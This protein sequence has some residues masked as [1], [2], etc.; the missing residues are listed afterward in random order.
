[1]WPPG[2]HVEHVESTGSTNVDLLVAAESGAPDRS[3][4]FTDHQ[5]AGRGRLDRVWTAPPGTNLL[6]S[7]LFRNVP[8]D[9]GELTRRVG[10]AAV[11]TASEVADVA[12][13]LKWPNDVLVDGRKL[14]GILAQRAQDGAVVIGLGMNV[15]WAPDGAARLGD[16]LEPP[17]VLASLLRC[18]DRLPDDVGQAYRSSLDT[19]GRRVR[20]ELPAG[21]LVGTAI[22]VESDGRL[23]VL[24]E[25]AVTHRVSAGD[26]VHLRPT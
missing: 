19:L 4:L 14:A 26:I 6:V 16:G 1:M 20:I 5:S 17:Q 18:F 15:G 25:C 9:P 24:D 2:W 21:E 13:V 22:D 23:V 8:N 10:L 11:G 3:V 12:A 7:L